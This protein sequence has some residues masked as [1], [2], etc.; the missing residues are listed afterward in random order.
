MLRESSTGQDAVADTNR[1]MILDSAMPHGKD[2][3]S[4]GPPEDIEQ[5]GKTG[6]DS[7]LAE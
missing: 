4:K 5:C 1:E 7:S 2:K 3:A 6:F